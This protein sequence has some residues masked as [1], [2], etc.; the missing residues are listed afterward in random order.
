MRRGPGDSPFS[1]TTHLARYH[2]GWVGAPSANASPIPA[3]TAQAFT[4]K[5]LTR[6]R[7]IAFYSSGA[8]S[9]PCRRFT[10]V[11]VDAVGKINQEHGNN[12]FEVVFVSHDVN[13]QEFDEKPRADSRLI[14]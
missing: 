9:P 1:S 8:W 12:T 11:L 5:D 4:K 14:C 3:Q 7:M 13:A 2:K 6:N 10:P